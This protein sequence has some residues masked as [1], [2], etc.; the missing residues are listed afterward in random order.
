MGTHL[1]LRIR[2]RVT[3]THQKELHHLMLP[4]LPTRAEWA[5]RWRITVKSCLYRTLDT[6]LNG[7]QDQAHRLIGSCPYPIPSL[8]NIK[9][10]RES[11]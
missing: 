1:D 7:A 10:H 5:I 4:K 8:V 2:D 9:L 3:L 11:V 6:A